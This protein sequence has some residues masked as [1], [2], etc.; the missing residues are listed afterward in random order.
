M[1]MNDGEAIFESQKRFQDDRITIR[2]LDFHAESGRVSIA[3]D[4]HR[5]NVGFYYI[6]INFQSGDEMRIDYDGGNPMRNTCPIFITSHKNDVL[7]EIKAKRIR[8]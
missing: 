5:P 2:L 6:W 7:K 3:V 1:E 4:E 8:D